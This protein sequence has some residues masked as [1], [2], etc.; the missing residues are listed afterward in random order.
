[1]IDSTIA[2][3]TATDDG[4]GIEN[5][6]GFTVTL[7]DSTVSNNSVNADVGGGFDNRGTAYVANTI[8]AGNSAT[9]KNSSD[10]DVHGV[11]TSTD[12]DLIGV[13]G[14]A[15]GFATT[16]S[17]ASIVLGSDSASA[18]SL[19][20]LAITA[21]RPKRWLFCQAAQ[22]STR[23]MPRP[24]RRS[25]C[26]PPTN[27]AKR[28]TS[29][30]TIDVGA[31]ETAPTT[32]YVATSFYDQTTGASTLSPNAGD[33]VNWLASGWFAE[34]DG[35][36]FGVNAF[37]SIQAAVNALGRTIDVAA[38][39]YIENV[40]FAR[41][42][43][44]NGAAV[45]TVLKGPSTLG[46]GIAIDTTAGTVNVAGLTISGFQTGVTVSSVSVANL[47]ADTITGNITGSG[48]FNHGTLA[49]SESS[50]TDNLLGTG[51]SGGGIVNGGAMTIYASTISGNFANIG[52]GIYNFGALT[53]SDSTIA[54]N[55]ATD[56][57]GG[58]E[59]ASGFTLILNDS[60]VSGNTVKSDVG[61]G[62]DNRG[63]AYVAN[64]IIAGNSATGKNASDPDVHGVFTSTDH[65]LIGVT[66]DATGFVTTGPTASIVLGSD[67]ASAVGLGPL[68]DNG[69]PTQTMAPLAGSLAIDSGDNAPPAPFS[70]P[71]A[72]QRGVT[73]FTASDPIIDIGAYEAPGVVPPAVTSFVVEKGLEERSYLRY[74]DVTFNTP[75]SGLTLDA[76]HVKLEHFGLN[77]ATDLGSIDLT[78]KISLVDKVME[79]DFGAG[80]IGGQENLPALLANWTKLIADDGYY[81]LVIDADGTGRHDIEL[82]FYRLFG[83]VIGNPTGGATTTGSSIS[84][85]LTYGV[86]TVIGQV[87]TA[88]VDSISAAVGE[89]GSL[90]NDDINGAGSV[91]PN[92]RL[93]AARS[94]G[95]QL[96][97]GLHLDD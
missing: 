8:I 36:T 61:G 4:G 1:M 25:A 20:P 92:D 41:P 28:A 16:G 72:D 6:G 56:D 37:T 34:V 81:K 43:S 57:G 44:I 12:H 96:A 35:L 48:I 23:A 59:N 51:G 79:I 47:T 70:L 89:T 26:P 85:S 90:L 40:E 76:A 73:R 80:G 30:G 50:V 18:I 75:V 10:P 7:E 83:D 17:T 32:L 68:A 2:G 24:A 74:L 53:V 46:T 13:T 64:T 86:P 19:G 65:D 9:G 33:T 93:L 66:G 45:Q 69:G 94:V 49:L 5:A 63:P 88:D 62:I 77:G 91:T 95:R 42:I 60:T 82:D 84:G 78:N 22:P 14:D 71:A 3:N 54:G 38:G 67:L 58:I 21:A 27:A 15:T 55:T 52:G 29:N 31:Y 39:T 11:F 87:T 97:A